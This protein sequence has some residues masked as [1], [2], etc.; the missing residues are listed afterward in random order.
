[1]L[2]E[3]TSISVMQNTF[4]ILQR[5]LALGLS[6]AEISRQSAIPK[7]RLSRWARGMTPAGADDAL[8]LQ[9]LELRISSKG[10]K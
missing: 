9:A 5:L 3:R 4:E 8:R 10:R 7:P 6:Q 2:Q 1:M